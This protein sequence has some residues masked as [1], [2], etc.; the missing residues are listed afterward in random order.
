M[1]AVV[2]GAAG[3]IGSHLCDRLLRDGHGV[4]G[5][6]RLNPRAN[7]RLIYRSLD[8]AEDDLEAALDGADV[9]FHLAARSGVRNADHRGFEE[10][11]HDNLI[12][13]E[14]LLDAVA[15]VQVGRLV[16][17]SSHAIYGEAE[18]LPT[19]ESAIPRPLSS[20]GVTKLAAESLAL[21]YSCNYGIPVTVLRYFSVYGPR[22]RPDMAVARFL[23]ALTGD[24]EIAIYGDGEQTRDLTYVADVVEAT[25]RAATADSKGNILN[26]GGGSRATLNE[27]L[28]A[29]EG[30][31]G[32]RVRRRYLPATKGDQRHSAAS[33]NKARQLLGWEPRVGLRLG[34]AEQWG[35]YRQAA[36][37][38]D[39]VVREAVTV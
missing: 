35:S 21:A 6:D 29:L 31:T 30:I 27:V 14:R 19:K 34:L 22:Q 33:I 36:R 17:A 9:V 12:A 18:R 3:F 7:A 11:V 39:G 13:T 28:T 8:L 20:E 32:R 5:V 23:D 38:A 26:I 15:R 16:F 1:R 2:T 25:V 24:R 4:V 37:G 10:F